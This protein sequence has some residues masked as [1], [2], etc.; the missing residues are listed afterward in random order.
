VLGATLATLVAVNLGFR[1]VVLV[2][3]GLYASA[4]FTVRRIA[5]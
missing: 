1:V 3:F 5:A 4:A 2:S